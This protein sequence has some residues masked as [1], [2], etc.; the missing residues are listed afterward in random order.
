M[1]RSFNTNVRTP[2]TKAIILFG[3][4]FMKFT[5]LRIYFISCIAILS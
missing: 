2:Q 5:Y 3:L 1:P 4:F